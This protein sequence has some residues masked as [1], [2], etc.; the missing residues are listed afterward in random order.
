MEKVGF[1]PGDKLFQLVCTA[2]DAMQNL[3]VEVHYLSCQ[4]GVGKPQ[5]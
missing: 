1:V 5:E 4:G 2:R 3:S